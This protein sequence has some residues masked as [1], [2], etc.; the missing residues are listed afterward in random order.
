MSR[1]S[2]VDPGIR[3]VTQTNDLQFNER[4][5]N[6]YAI[7]HLKYIDALFNCRSMLERV[8]FFELSCA[9]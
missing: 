5:N 4:Y 8:L 7:S 3:K 1:V 2:P 9:R 6:F